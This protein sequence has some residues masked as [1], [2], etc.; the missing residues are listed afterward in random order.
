M[1]ACL[2]REVRLINKS[3]QI[4]CDNRRSGGIDDVG[5]IPGIDQFPCVRFFEWLLPVQLPADSPL[6]AREF[7]RSFVIPPYRR[8]V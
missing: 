1:N 4:T 7:K 5:C 8:R 6:T 2:D 3:R